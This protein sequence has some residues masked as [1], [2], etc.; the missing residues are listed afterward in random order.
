MV[1]STECYEMAWLWGWRYVQLSVYILF[2]QTCR[3]AHDDLLVSRLAQ[4]GKQNHLKWKNIS[5][6]N[7]S[8]RPPIL[9][10]EAAAK[11]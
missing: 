4:A 10:R 3:S 8:E 5:I 1:N 9:D 2:F 7:L 11:H 6:I